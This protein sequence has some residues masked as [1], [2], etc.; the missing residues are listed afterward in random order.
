MALRNNHTRALNE[1]LSIDAWHAI[2]DH[3]GVRALHIDVSFREARIGEEQES[4]VRFLLGIRRA[5]IS[6]IIPPNEEIRVL[7]NSV[8]REALEVGTLQSQTEN[9]STGSLEAGAGV[10]VTATPSVDAHLKTS[11]TLSTSNKRTAM[12]SRD[13][14]DINWRQFKD[15]QGNYCWEVS[16]FGSN[17]MV[18][19][20]WSVQSEPRLKFRTSADSKIAPVARVRAQCRREDMMIDKIELKNPTR[21]ESLASRFSKNKIA[22]AEA[23]IKYLLGQESLEHNNISEKFSSV[24]LAETTVDIGVI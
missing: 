7:Q 13:I 20:P 17:H 11:T 9:L 14:S 22:A 2:D 19:K 4:K 23:V 15:S 24:L 10:Q 16:A 6:F 5:E 8:A 21:T 3:E 1:V 18:G 12:L